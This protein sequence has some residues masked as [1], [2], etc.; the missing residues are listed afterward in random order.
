[1]WRMDPKLKERNDAV[2]RVGFTRLAILFY[3]M[4]GLPVTLAMVVFA[5]RDDV[6]GP[7]SPREVFI[8]WL[9]I[10][11]LFVI[12]GSLYYRKIMKL[13]GLK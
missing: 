8:R 6:C 10:V 4:I 9:I 13:A 1:M 3:V 12:S 7:P 11:T 5:Y 2:C